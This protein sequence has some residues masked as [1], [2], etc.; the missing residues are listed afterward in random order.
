MIDIGSCTHITELASW[1]PLAPWESRHDQSVLLPSQEFFSSIFS[2][3]DQHLAE[4]TCEALQNYT[5]LGKS[6]W[7]EYAVP[8][9]YCNSC[10]CARIEPMNFELWGSAAQYM[11]CWSFHQNQH[12]ATSLSHLDHHKQYAVSPQRV[13]HSFFSCRPLH[14][15]GLGKEPVPDQ[16]FFR[17][18]NRT[19]SQGNH[20]HWGA[21]PR[22][23]P[24]Y[25]MWRPE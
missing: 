15:S 3:P 20:R 23:G 10:S 18:R 25:R 5:K 17:F 21:P 8:R 22:K 9:S 24:S 16:A 14:T 19:A 7:H 12:Q 4:V 13:V 11:R 6:S 1:M 2:C